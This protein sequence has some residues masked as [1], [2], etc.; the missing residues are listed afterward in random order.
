[1]FAR[2]GFVILTLAQIRELLADVDQVA[3][4]AFEDG[5]RKAQ[6]DTDA[7]YDQGYEH[8]HAQ[9]YDEGYHEGAGDAYDD[10]Y[11]DGKSEAE[12]HAAEQVMF[13]R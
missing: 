10:G 9:G 6:E 7:A 5:C 1:M 11:E 2:E 8:G 13:G 4:G 3:L 12:A